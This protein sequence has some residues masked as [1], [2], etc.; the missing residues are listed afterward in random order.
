MLNGLDLFTGIGGITL[1]LS[2]WVKPV[3]YCE[4]DPYC[5]SLLLQRMQEGNLPKAPIWD[6]VQTLPHSELPKIDIIYGGFPCQD[7][8]VAGI[9]KGLEGERSALFFEIVRLAKEIKPPFIFLENVSAIRGR[10]LNRVGEELAK[11]RYDCRWGIISAR[12]IGARHSRK[13]WFLLAYSTS[14]R[15]QGERE[16]A[17]QPE[18]EIPGPSLQSCSGIVRDWETEPDVARL[19]SHG[20]FAKLG[21]D[22]DETL[23]KLWEGVGAETVWKKAGR[24]F[25]LSEK[26]TLQ[27]F[28]YG[29]GDGKRISIEISDTE[30]AFEVERGIMRVMQITEKS[31][32]S[33]HRWKL[34]KQQYAKFDDALF[35]LS[36]IFASQTGRLDRE[37]AEKALLY[38][39][40]GVLSIKS[41]LYSSYTLQEAWESL[42]S[43]WKESL[44]MSPWN[45]EPPIPRV[46]DGIPFRVD[47][48]K[49]LGNAVVPLQVREAFLRLSRIEFS[50]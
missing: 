3:A 21:K 43:T 7:I 46:A 9:G 24:Y 8:S 37:E 12:E 29:E 44:F 35:A 6:D 47:R 31:L 15:C 14:I 33:P 50:F 40:S 13:R 30:K 23:L 39:W 1:A 49:A 42:D 34:G 5:Q 22:I 10:G 26:K 4:I 20:I 25:Y 48:I 17:E 16:R 11:L 19:L 45:I 36:Y 28:M 27:P 32:R 41:M 38:L 18:K 2:E